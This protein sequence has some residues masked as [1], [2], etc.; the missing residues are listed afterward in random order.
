MNKSKEIRGLI[1]ESN[2]ILICSHERP[3]GDAIGSV[4]GLG[5]SLKSLGKNVQMV[6][7]DDLSSNFDFIPEINT[8]QKKILHP[9]DLS[10]ILDCSDKFRS[11]ILFDEEHHFDVNIDHHI[12]N[13]NFAKNNI[14]EP[15]AAATAQILTRLLLEWNFPIIKDVATSL[16][17]GILTDTLGFRTSNVT[18]ETF[19]ISAKL[20]ENGTNLPEIYQ[21]VLLS[22]SFQAS[23]YWGSGLSNL[24]IENSLVW[25]TLTLEDRKKAA[26][27]GNDDAD[28][29]NMLSNIEEANIILLFI[30]QKDEKV[31]VSWRAKTGWD[32]SQIALKYG[33]GG[34]PAA[35]GTMLNGTLDEITTEILIETKKHL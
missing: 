18:E 14:V 25:T 28:L 3:D 13:S 6:F 7:K 32:V 15:Q 26:Y 33:G 35:A 31:K 4:I 16:L 29:I 22:R 23:K 30:E 12:T 19:Q 24:Q 11:G 1:L 9:F 20:I 10:I 8:I 27:R 17:T 2:N 5:L 34:H 21:K